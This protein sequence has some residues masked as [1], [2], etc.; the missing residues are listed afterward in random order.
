MKD[1]DQQTKYR[2][3]PPPKKKDPDGPGVNVTILKYS[4]QK[5]EIICYFD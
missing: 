1:G 2:A 4:R 5:K 3:F